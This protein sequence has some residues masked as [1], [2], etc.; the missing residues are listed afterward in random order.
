MPDAGR[1]ALGLRPAPASS[2]RARDVV[3]EGGSIDVNGRG[4][5]LTTE[6]C[7]LDPE[8]QVRN[9]GFGAARTTRASSATPWARRT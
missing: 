2:T 3:L 1:A 8:V 7:L 5:L 9:P 4:T 6:E